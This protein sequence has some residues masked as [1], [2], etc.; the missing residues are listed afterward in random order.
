MQA[1]DKLR[2]YIQL[3]RGIDGVAGYLFSIAALPFKI[4]FRVSGEGSGDGRS[5]TTIQE[6]AE[7]P[8]VI[9]HGSLGASVGGQFLHILRES[10]LQWRDAFFALSAEAI[11]SLPMLEQGASVLDQPAVWR[12]IVGLALM[13]EEQAASLSCGNAVPIYCTNHQDGKTAAVFQCKECGPA[14]YLCASCDSCLHLS[15]SRRNHKREMASGTE[16]TMT[17]T[18]K[19]GETARVKTATIVLAVDNTS[20]VAPTF[21]AVL[22]IKSL[23]RLAAE[24]VCRFCDTGIDAEQAAGI[25]RI[26]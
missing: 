22:E 2:A 20:T 12:A 21:N 26:S 13:G 19:K 8:V 1:T 23:A 11:Q 17:V 9:R 5:R 24:S 10:P 18:A 25:V 16:A 7:L 15:L 6:R 3:V 14:V 4:H